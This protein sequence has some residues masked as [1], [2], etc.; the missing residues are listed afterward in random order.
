MSAGHGPPPAAYSG[1]VASSLSAE[2]GPL[3]V[4]RSCSP[5]VVAAPG[6][7][8]EHEPLRVAHGHGPAAAAALGL[9]VGHGPLCATRGRGPAA[10]ATPGLSVGH[11][12][13]RATRSR[14]PAATAGLRW[15]CGPD[16]PSYHAPGGEGMLDCSFLT[17]VSDSTHKLVALERSKSIGVLSPIHHDG[18]ECK[19]L[20]LEILYECFGQ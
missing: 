12:P 3:R 1:N 14:S 20:V 8:T 13:L 9:S 18:L 6:L 10:T 4:A 5:A 16:S 2:H 19:H 7:S 15:T 17:F 11:G